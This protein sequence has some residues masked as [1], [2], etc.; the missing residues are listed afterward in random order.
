MSPRKLYPIHFRRG[1]QWQSR[2]PT[3]ADYLNLLDWINSFLVFVSHNSNLFEITFQNCWSPILM[4]R[5]V[6]KLFLTIKEEGKRNPSQQNQHR[7]EFVI[8]FQTTV[9]SIP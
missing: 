9:K 4:Q 8:A 3:V 2:L 6:W 7:R 1:H 5:S